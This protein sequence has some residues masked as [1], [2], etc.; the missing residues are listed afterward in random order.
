M[1]E[2]IDDLKE[3]LTYDDLTENYDLSRSQARSQ[4]DDLK[5]QGYSI[6]EKTVNKHGKK[7]FILEHEPKEYTLETEGTLGFASDTHLGSKAEQL[8]SLHKY[9]DEIE[10]K[11]INIVFHAGDLS[12]GCYVYR[13]Q[14]HE[15]KP[16]AIGWARLLDYVEENYPEREGVTTFVIEGNHDRKF[17]QQNGLFFTEEIAKRRDDIEFLGDGFAEVELEDLD[18]DIQLVHPRGGV[19]YTLGYRAQDWMREKS[20]EDKPDFAELGHIHKFLEGKTEGVDFVY[21]GCFQGET[22]YTQTKGIKPRA[23]AWIIKFE[24]ENGQKIISPT[25]IEYPLEQKD[26]KIISL[27]SEENGEE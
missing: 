5:D 8:K 22:E 11:D 3:G 18:M 25:R 24:K 13:G 14:R 12:D 16:E 10:D 15:K 4:I 27:N 17:Y 1:D 23:G 2:I 26:K 19:P 21:G 9:Y 20:E 6:Q 7:M